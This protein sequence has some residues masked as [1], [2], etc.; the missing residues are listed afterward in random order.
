VAQPPS[1]AHLGRPS[2]PLP[3][4]IPPPPA[5]PT[6]PAS[7]PLVGPRAR[8]PARP[9]ASPRQPHGPASVAPAAQRA[10]RSPSPRQRSPARLRASRPSARA[11]PASQP[12]CAPTAQRALRARMDACHRRYSL[13]PRVREPARTVHLPQAILA[14]FSRP[15]RLQ[16]RTAHDS[17]AVSRPPPLL[18][19]SPPLS[20]S[21]SLSE[22]R[23]AEVSSPPFSLHHSLPHFF[24]VSACCRSPWPELG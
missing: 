12:R 5:R 18:L 2:R 22:C 24:V 8:G 20:A 14:Q 4:L 1:L 3:P 9:A 21:P 23:V 6:A 10:C 11:S 16:N 19:A 7:L 13:G 15:R 17:C